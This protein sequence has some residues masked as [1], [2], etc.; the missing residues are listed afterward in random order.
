[1]FTAAMHRHVLDQIE[2]ET[3]LR[4]I[5]E[6]RRLRVFYQPVVDLVS[7]DLA[8][9]EALARWPAGGEPVSPARFVAVAED[10]GQIADLGRLVLDEACERLADWR[11][12]GIAGPDMTMSVNVSGRQLSD[13]RRLVDD[14]QAAL[15]TSGLPPTCLRLEITES[16]VI[17]RP[18]RARLA[19][20]ELARLGVRAEIDDFGT[21]YASL[22]FLTRYPLTR[23]KI[24][25]SFVR[26][27]AE[28]PA[29]ED[30]AI[31]RSIIM[32]AHN[33]GMEVIAEGVETAAQAAFLQAEQCDEAQGFLYAKPLP[34]GEFEEFLVASQI[35]S[36]ARREKTSAA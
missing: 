19:L 13:P 5:I 21:G 16:T 2:L 29:L 11:L 25:Q 22:S 10:T 17:S 8:G 7:G 32:M 20:D 34:L 27:I 18:E 12:R 15:S 33:L 23:L 4:A 14:V 24:D 3:E 36:V 26:K 31:V 9:F 1:V 6:E 28:R 35:R 30:T